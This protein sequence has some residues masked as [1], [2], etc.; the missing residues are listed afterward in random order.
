MFAK[1]GSIQEFSESFIMIQLGLQR[2]ES[3]DFESILF[4]KVT[5]Y[6]ADR[7]KS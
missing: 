2:N 7:A 3:I 5:L 6:A 1:D 4:I